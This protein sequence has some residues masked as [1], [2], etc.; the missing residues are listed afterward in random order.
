[1]SDFN[2]EGGWGVEAV[3][4]VIRQALYHLGHVYPLGHDQAGLHKSEERDI[5]YD[6]SV[7]THI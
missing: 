4:G 5:M 6:Y 3:D 7:L 1:M 2:G